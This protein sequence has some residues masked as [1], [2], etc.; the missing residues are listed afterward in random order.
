[1]A[2]NEGKHVDPTIPLPRRNE[3]GPWFGQ[4]RADLVHESIVQ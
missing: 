4:L 3:T 2:A 1:M